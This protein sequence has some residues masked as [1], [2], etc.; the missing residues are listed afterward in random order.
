[1]SGSNFNITDLLPSSIPDNLRE[2]HSLA[3]LPPEGT[4]P[5]M[6]FRDFPLNQGLDIRAT[7]FESLVWRWPDESF[8]FI[9]TKYANQATIVYT[10]DQPFLQCDGQVGTTI[11]RNT[12]IFGTNTANT[13]MAFDLTALI[14]PLT[15][16]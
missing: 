14:A 13:A 16:P 1:M 15:N 10:G 5:N 12:N 6:G 11:I 8:I 4:G 7:I 2:V 9:W 3:D